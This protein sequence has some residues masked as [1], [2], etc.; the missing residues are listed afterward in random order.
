MFMKLNDIY[1]AQFSSHERGSFGWILNKFFEGP[2]IDKEYWL[3]DTRFISLY[4]GHEIIGVKLEGDETVVM[5]PNRGGRTGTF[6]S[7]HNK[8]EMP[9]HLKI[10]SSKRLV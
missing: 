3:D 8:E 5:I 2:N 6:T 7:S 1:E 9:T 10:Y 4:Q